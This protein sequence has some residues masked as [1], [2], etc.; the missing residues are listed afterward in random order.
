M[1]E[2]LTKMVQESEPSADVVFSETDLNL[3]TEDVVSEEPQVTEE[4]QVAS[5]IGLVSLSEWFDRNTAN[6]DNISA[7]RV[8]IRGVDPNKTLIVAVNEGSGETDE[9]G[10]PKRELQLFKNADVHPVLD[11][12]GID[13]QVYNN[14]FKIVHQFSGDIFIKCYGVRTGLIAVFCINI[15]G[16]LIPYHIKKVKKK[17]TE[18]EAVPANSG[19]QIQARLNAPANIEALQLLYKQ[20][21]KVASELQTNQQVIDWLIARQAEVTDINHH[22]QIDSVLIDI[23]R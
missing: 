5:T 20:S 4:P 9:E 12:E 7:V 13:M 15:G 22:F 14:G 16:K 18:I 2:N 11:L 1:N 17:D 21:S 10:N 8:S 23:L 6:F 3:G 19:D